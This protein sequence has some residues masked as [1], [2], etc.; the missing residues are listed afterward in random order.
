MPEAAESGRRDP[1]GSAAGVMEEALSAAEAEAFARLLVENRRRI[2]LYVATLVPDWH[3]AEE[4]VQESTIYLWQEFQRFEP[5]TSFAGWA[6]KVAYFRVLAWRKRK[7]RERLQFSSEF[8]NSVAEQLAARP[9]RWEEREKRLEQCV[10]RLSPNH[11]RILTLRYSEG[12]SIDDVAARVG[13]TVPAT[14][15]LLSRI[16]QTL[17]EC[18]KRHMSSDDERQR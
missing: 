5:G 4:I 8:L 7:G 13:R 1:G 9:E 16:R 10:E 6:C 3:D 18:V 12:C 2:S 15:C 14:Y 11:R 17:F